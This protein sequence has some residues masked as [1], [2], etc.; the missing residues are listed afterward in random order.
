MKRWGKP[1]SNQSSGAP[2]A[3]RQSRRGS[4]ARMPCVPVLRLPACP[5]ACLAPPRP[6]PPTF[7]WIPCR[8]GTTSSLPQQDAGEMICHAPSSA[9]WR[10][11]GSA[12]LSTRLT[13]KAG[14]PRTTSSGKSCREGGRGRR[15]GRRAGRQ[16]G[17]LAGSGRRWCH[18]ADSWQAVQVTIVPITHNMS[19][20]TH[21]HGPR[22]AAKGLAKLLADGPHG[23]ADVV[24]HRR[25]RAPHA[26][27]HRHG[28]RAQYGA[29]VCGGRSTPGMA[30]AA[31]WQ[32]RVSSKRSGLHAMQSSKP[33]KPQLRPH[34]P[35]L[36]QLPPASSP[37]PT[38]SASSFPKPSPKR[39]EWGRSCQAL[40]Q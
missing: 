13:A 27:N 28:L 4:H 10:K 37:A 18:H 7:S 17:G 21:R 15:A 36:P 32:S 24:R 11:W 20:R 40:R 31:T 3:G 39:T 12:A 34:A 14:P 25:Q 38:R 22:L 1:V 33:A 8:S 26:L 23:L 30:R 6:A 2:Q 29:G 9:T 35:Q 5:V 19:S 16:T